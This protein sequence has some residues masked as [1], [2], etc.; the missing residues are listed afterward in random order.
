MIAPKIRVGRPAFIRSV[1]DSPS[2][3][4]VSSKIVMNDC[5]TARSVSDGS[6]RRGLRRPKLS[7]QSYE[8]GARRIW[9]S[10]R[11]PTSR[12]AS[13]ATARTASRE[14]GATF[15][16]GSPAGSTGTPHTHGSPSPPAITPAFRVTEGE[17]KYCRPPSAAT[18]EPKLR[19]WQKRN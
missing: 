1:S 15:G 2:V 19:P 12:G 14:P 7:S 18:A 9:H 3:K 16:V 11:K 6:A 8:Y 4:S 17:F 13:M 10:H 5:P